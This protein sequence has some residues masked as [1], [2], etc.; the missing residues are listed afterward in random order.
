VNFTFGR[1]L[2]PC[3]LENAFNLVGHK[4]HGRPGD[5]YLDRFDEGAGSHLYVVAPSAPTDAV[6][7][8]SV[9]LLV[10]TNVSDFEVTGLALNEAT[11]QLDENGYTQAQAGTYMHGPACGSYNASDPGGHNN[12]A[13][14]PCPN[15]GFDKWAITPASVAVHGGQRVR[16]RNCTF[17]RLGASGVAFDRGEHERRI[18]SAP[19]GLLLLTWLPPHEHRWLSAHPAFCVQGARTAPWRRVCWRTS[20]GTACRSARS[21]A[22]TSATPAPRTRTTLWWTPSCGAWCAPPVPSTLD[23]SVSW[24]TTKRRGCEFAHAG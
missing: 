5:Y 2:L 17:S 15:S 13:G 8:Q 22:T 1:N 12:S 3:F 6:L 21:T 7:P 23:L 9:G 19:L 14:H 20:A 18:S 10:L 4:V 16:F 11:W 24:L